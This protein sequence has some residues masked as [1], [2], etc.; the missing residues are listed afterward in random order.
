[1]T[2]EVEEVA[3]RVGLLSYAGTVV[4]R[5]SFTSC[6]DERRLSVSG[7]PDKPT[8]AKGSQCATYY[9]TLPETASLT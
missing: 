1:M 4:R 5:L 6:E 9:L 3:T 2:D 8:R 7:S